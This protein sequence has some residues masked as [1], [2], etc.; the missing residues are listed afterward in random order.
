M[1]NS[2]RSQKMKQGDLRAP[3]PHEKGERERSTRSLAKSIPVLVTE[4]MIKDVQC[5]TLLA[6]MP[7]DL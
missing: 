4:G 6:I 2:A 3:K 7:Y 5:R 1:G